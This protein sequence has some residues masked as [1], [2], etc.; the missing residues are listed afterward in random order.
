MGGLYASLRLLGYVSAE[1]I[2]DRTYSASSQFMRMLIEEKKSSFAGY[3]RNRMYRNNGDGTFTEVGYLEGVDSISDGYI[4]VK[5]DINKDGRQDIILR[6]GDPAQSEYKFP[7]IE[8]FQNQFKNKKALRI[9][10][11]GAKSTKDAL[12]MG[13]SVVAK[14]RKQYKQVISNNGPAQSELTLHFGLDDASEAS[15]VTIE[16]PSGDQVI[17]NLK[18]GNH[19]FSEEKGI[20]IA[21]KF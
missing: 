17:H 20:K 16:W 2:E 9:S 10:L 5:G 21:K 11:V 4:L 7:A 14:G 3:Q 18:A 8:V 19:S 13:V 15:K 6:N 12:G 1:E